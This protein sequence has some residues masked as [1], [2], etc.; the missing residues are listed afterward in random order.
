MLLVDNNNKNQTTDL[1]KA[2]FMKD[3]VIQD[4]EDFKELL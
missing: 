2:L 4:R 1:I 3:N